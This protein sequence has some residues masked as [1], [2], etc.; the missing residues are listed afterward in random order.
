MKALIQ[1]AAVTLAVVEGHRVGSELSVAISPFA[2]SAQDVSTESVETCYNTPLLPDDIALASMPCYQISLPWPLNRQVQFTREGS[3]KSGDVDLVRWTQ[4]I[5]SP[6]YG[7]T[8]F[9]SAHDMNSVGS[10]QKV[11]GENAVLSDCDEVPFKRMYIGSPPSL[12]EVPEAEEVAPIALQRSVLRNETFFG[13]E[14]EIE[15]LVIHLPGNS[16]QV[17][18]L[19]Q[20]YK[21]ATVAADTCGVPQY[22][23]RFTSLAPTDRHDRFA[24]A[25][26][27]QAWILENKAESATIKGTTSQGTLLVSPASPLIGAMEMLGGLIV[28]GIYFWAIFE[29]CFLVLSF[30]HPR[31]KKY[32]QDFRRPESIPVL[33]MED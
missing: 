16:S 19:V 23:M 8:Y 20:P 12:Y 24:I 18:A 2:D 30:K 7:H 29:Y 6:Y 17:V 25:A 33:H 27:A 26:L 11:D 28:I 31:I 32:A 21:N 3:W 5:S 4:D 22:N 15:T 13:G 1:N 9:Q 10:V 14:N